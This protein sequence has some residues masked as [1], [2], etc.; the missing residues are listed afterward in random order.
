MSFRSLPNKKELLA[1]L[2]AAAGMGIVATLLSVYVLEEEPSADPAPALRLALE[3]CQIKLEDTESF[4]EN[5]LIECER[6]I[7]YWKGQCLLRVE[8]CEGVLQTMQEVN[9]NIACEAKLL[10]FKHGFYY[11][12]AQR[13]MAERQL[14][15]PEDHGDPQPN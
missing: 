12:R 11:E 8:G 14:E 2:I 1:L 7:E 10:T 15:S 6:E 4:S 13:K 3:E 9:T 5:S